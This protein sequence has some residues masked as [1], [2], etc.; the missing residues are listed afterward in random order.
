VRLI[1]AAAAG[2]AYYPESP[3]AAAPSDGGLLLVPRSYVFGSEELSSLS[4]GIRERS[5]KPHVA[6]GP[7]EAA[8]LGLSAGQEVQVRTDAGDVLR[9]PLEVREIPA[10]IAVIPRGLR[11]LEGPELP[12]RARITGGRP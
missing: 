12:V 11:G 2:G 4:P 9:L 3:A 1:E 6:L 5:P 8:R 10:G 7:E